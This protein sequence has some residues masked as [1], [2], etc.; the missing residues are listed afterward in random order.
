MDDNDDSDSDYDDCN[1]ICLLIIPP[2]LFGETR[3]KRKE[4]WMTLRF[5]N[6][7][8]GT[9]RKRERERFLKEVQVIGNER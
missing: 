3:M 8:R 6:F 9:G 1:T 2:P 5:L 4:L 7:C